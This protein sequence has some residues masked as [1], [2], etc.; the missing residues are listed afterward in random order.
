MSIQQIVREMP[1]LAM[2]L[3]MFFLAISNNYPIFV[4]NVQRAREEY[5]MLVKSGQKAVPVWKQILKSLFSWQTAMTTGIMLLVMYGKEIGN[6]VSSLFRG[7]SAFDTVS[8]SAEIFHA[9][10]LE[11]VKNAQKEK[12]ELDLL[13]KAAT[14]T[15]RS[16]EE[17]VKAVSKLQDIYPEYFGNMSR[18]QIMLG[19]ARDRYDELTAAIIRTAR[20]EAARDKIAENSRKIL[21]IQASKEYQEYA[22][23]ARFA[24]ESSI[25][26]LLPRAQGSEE[27][28]ARLKWELERSAEVQGKTCLLYTSPSPRD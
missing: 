19:Q 28:A 2:G 13:Y 4:D 25:E 21:D 16:T 3:Q 22:S 9:T 1:S 10:M 12:T 11:G 18:E 5:D 14:D 15:S 27:G 24:E 6:F 7:K 20:A 8:R 26:S 23:Q 17:R